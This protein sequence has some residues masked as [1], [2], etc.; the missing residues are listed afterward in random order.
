[1]TRPERLFS[2]IQPTG[3]VHVGNYL[4]AI[5]NWVRL[6]ERYDC[7]YCIVD[8][9]AMTMRYEAA[10]MPG[11]ILDLAAVLLA[12]GLTQDRCT[13][14]V[15]SEV[16]EHAELCWMLS[17][18]AGLGEL[19]RMTQF[20]DKSSQDRDN[21]NLGLLAYPVLQTADII[22]F[23][24]TA[25]PVGEDQLQHLELARE[26]VR[27]FNRKFGP[28]F[29]EPQALTTPGAR[30]LG[31]DGQAKMSKSLNN[32][33]GLVEPPEVIWEKLR[34]A[35]TDPQ[36]V[37]RSDPGRPEVCNIYSLHRHFS[38][39]PRIQFVER[40]CRS[41]GIGCIDC[42]KLLAESMEAELGPIRQRYQEW[43]ENLE[44]VRAALR[45]GVERATELARQTMSEVRRAVGLRE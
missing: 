17:T 27:R 23:K 5:R 19:E 16:P 40:E 45:T 39:P 26:I 37:R 21:V 8:Y 30:I 32:F 7:I 18:V 24:A 22:L 2:G 14:Y 43:T 15:Q 35:V 1:M 25:V 20:K 41:A 10:A 6:L 12:S 28:V 3:V 34:P 38:D 13:L 29:P 33:I 9:H 44:R 11:R 36:R 4:G 31:L 42:K